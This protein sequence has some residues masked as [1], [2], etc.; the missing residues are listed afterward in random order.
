MRGRFLEPERPADV[1]DPK[2]RSDGRERLEDVDHAVDDLRADDPIPVAFGGCVAGVERR[3][4]TIQIGVGGRGCL[5]GIEVRRGAG[6][7]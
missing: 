6:V 7:A 5:D 4:G 2:L 3:R 1:A